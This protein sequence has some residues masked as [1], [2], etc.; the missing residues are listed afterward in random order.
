[1]KNDN[2]NFLVSRLKIGEE[3]AYN[4]LIDLY[5]QRLYGYALSLTRD[6]AQSQDILQNVFLKTWEKRKKLD[7]HTSLKNFL[8]RAVY[9]EFINQYKKKRAIMVLEQTYYDS[10]EKAVLA[11]D[12]PSYERINKEITKEIKRLPLKCQQVFILSKLEGLTNTEIANY[13][14]VSIKTVEAQITKAFNIIRGKVRTKY[15]MV[16]I[17]VLGKN[18]RG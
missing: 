18:A 8:Y 11:Q 13:L 14:N 12:D 6:H 10:L 5:N 7:I 9:N 15:D 2:N 4:S 3:T 17:I 1:M 16:F